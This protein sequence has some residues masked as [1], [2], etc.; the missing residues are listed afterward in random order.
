M[1]LV[2]PSFLRSTIGRSYLIFAFLCGVMSIGVGVVSYNSTLRWFEVNKGEEKITA[3]QLVD[4]FVAT[5]TRERSQFLKNDA[6]VPASFR[7]QAIARFNEARDNASALHILWVGPPGREI[8]TAPTDDE[9]AATVES[10]SNEAKPE[11]VTHFVKVHDALLFRTVYPSVA[12]QQ[13]CVDCHNQ[14]QIGK[15]QWHLNDVM[16]ASVLD[17]PADPF[18]RQ[19]LHDSVLTGLAV[20]LF[21]TTIGLITFYLQYREFARRAK[22][23]ASLQL[24][25]LEIRELNEVLE[26]RVEERTAELRDAQQ[27]LLRK[28]RLA[29]LGQLTATVSHELRNPL[30]V[31]RN[32]FYSLGEVVKQGGLRLD[33]QL[34]RIDRN[35]TRCND[36]I[37]KMLD[38]TRTRELDESPQVFDEWLREVLDEYELPPDIVLRRELGAPGIHVMFDPGRLQQVFVNLLDN[39][40]DAITETR[41]GEEGGG[42]GDAASI[43]IRTSAFADRLDV[44]IHD[45]GGGIPAEVL[46]K[47]FEPLFSTKG[48]GV[49]LGLPTVKQIVEQHGGAIAIDSTPGN[50]ATVALSFPLTQM[51]ETAA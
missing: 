27:T 13:D 12:K 34:G 26:R 18:L 42:A 45:T 6:P 48:F 7:A 29:T 4:A 41:S 39:A 30:G 11:A 23:E 3:A 33:R 19:S 9:M 20:F 38:Y 14:V 17:V 32:T 47:I 28:E 46:P 15:V 49:G 51:Q 24:A 50:G 40:R 35:I 21:S 8:A 2:I 1:A 36:I 10:F 16:G 5:Y 22:S 37:T 44:S 31:I 25:H 43:T